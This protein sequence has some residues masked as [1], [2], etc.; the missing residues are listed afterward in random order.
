MVNGDKVVVDAMI[1]D[2]RVRAISFVGSTRIARYVYE[3]GARAGK[4]VQCQ[5]AAKNFLTVMPDANLDAAIPN[6]VS[7]FYGNTGQRCLAGACLVPVGDRADEVVRLFLEASSRLKLGYGLDPSVH[8][9]PLAARKHYDRVMG[10]IETGI[11]EGARLL[12]DG[13]N[14]K[15][16][17]Y[18]GGCFVGPT[19]FDGVEPGMTLAREEIFGPV[20]SIVRARDLDHAIR[21]ANGSDFG[22]ASSIYTSSGKSARE[23]KYRVKGG[24]I[25]I[26]VGVAAPMAFF[27]FGGMKDSFFG[28]LHGQGR[29]GVN[30][31]TDRKVVITRWM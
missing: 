23:Y 19:I 1:E 13:R 22:N 7:S 28:D 2:P 25:G 29:D 12:L 8:M 15:V 20:V 31:F 3:Q 26:N 10:Y 5:G 21:L 27:P 9:G 4:R 11:R 24:N 18:E 16:E 17:G 30:F 6:L 14:P